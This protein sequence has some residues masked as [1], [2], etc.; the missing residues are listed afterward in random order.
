MQFIMNTI[1]LDFHYYYCIGKRLLMLII[2]FFVIPTTIIT[3]I[4]FLFNLYIVVIVKVIDL[5]Y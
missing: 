2:L 1:M 3:Y 4:K 5:Q